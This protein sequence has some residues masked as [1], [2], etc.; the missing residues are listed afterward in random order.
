MTWQIEAEHSSA[1]DLLEELE[2]LA[3]SLFGTCVQALFASREEAERARR[4]LETHLGLTPA[5]HEL[6]AKDWV[7]ENVRSFP[8]LVVGPFAIVHGDD[9]A[10]ASRHL[11]RMK[12]G[13]GF[14]TGEHPSTAGCLKALAALRTPPRTVLD[15][16]CGSAILS[17]AAAVLWDCHIIAVDNDPLALSFAQSQI[18]GNGLARRIH[19]VCSHAFSAFSP[20]HFDLVVANILARPLIDMAPAIRAGTVILSGFLVDQAAP[21]LEAYRQAGYAPRA[22]IITD[23]WATLTLASSSP[24]CRIKSS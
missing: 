13:A 12:A 5:L 10:D 6:P 24:V 14:G 2:P 23:D 20:A 11:I 19:L 1:H 7:A 3:L 15:M 16:G 17:I 4:H 21:V 8:P 22:T 9:P 18:A